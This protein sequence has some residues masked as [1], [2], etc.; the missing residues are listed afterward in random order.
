MTRDQSEKGHRT[1][2]TQEQHL[3][4]E[5]K[6]LVAVG[7]S[8]GAGCQPCVSHHLKAGAKAGL[9][10]EQLL[11]AVTSAERVSAEAAVAMGDHARGKLGPTVTSLALLPRLEEALASLGAALGAND[12]QN[13]ER[14]LRA[15]AD[16]GATRSQLEQ[17]IETAHNVQENAARIHLREAERLL[18]AI[19]PATAAAASDA[20]PG[21]C[22][23]GADEKTEEAPV[24]AKESEPVAASNGDE[25]GEGCGCG[26]DENTE[27]APDTTEEPE[28][29]AATSGHAGGYGAMAAHVAA[30]GPPPARWRAAARCSSGSPPL[31]RLQRPRKRRLQQPRPAHARRRP[32]DDNDR[33]HRRQKLEHLDRRRLDRPDADRD[34]AL[35]RLHARLHVADA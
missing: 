21:S 2:T 34:G 6:E 23:C 19:A 26:A 33:H 18:D 30:A 7:A 9:D 11:A 29:V 5:Q 1:M 4:P 20:D 28:P 35:P 3:S 13:I 25:S 31:P 17:V 32:D 16:L 14:Q 10:G 24:T 27:E 15:A 22:G 8:V 12:K